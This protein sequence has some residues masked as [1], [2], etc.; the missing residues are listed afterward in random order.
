MQDALSAKMLTF[1]KNIMIRE[2][3]LKLCTEER[4]SENRFPLAYNNKTFEKKNR[5]QNKNRKEKLH[6]N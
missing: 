2:K 3:H 1:E 5:K 6:K 4:Q